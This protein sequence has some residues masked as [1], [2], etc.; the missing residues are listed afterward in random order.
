[1]N[2]KGIF[3]GAVLVGTLLLQAQGQ[4]LDRFQIGARATANP[5]AGT[6]INVW[7]ANGNEGPEKAIDGLAAKYLNFGELNTGYILTLTGAEIVTGLNLTTANDGPERDPTSFSLWGSNT[8]TANTT[9]G[10]VFNLS[11]FT[12]ITLDSPLTL[13]TGRNTA[14]PLVSFPN[15]TAFTT[16]LLVFPTVRNEA[17][18]N[19]MQI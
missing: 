5:G 9:P 12:P 8:A 3:F 19:S 15:P 17:T 14:A 2:I 6:N 4:I 10:T 11:S 7:P 16:Y 13:P 18:A 1:M